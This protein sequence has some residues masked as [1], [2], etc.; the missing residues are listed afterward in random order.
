MEVYLVQTHIPYEGSEL[1]SICSNK[2][3][4]ISKARDIARRSSCGAVESEEGD[5]FYIQLR[6]ESISVTRSEVEDD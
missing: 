1:E 4:A 3:L 5:S 2:E 6:Y